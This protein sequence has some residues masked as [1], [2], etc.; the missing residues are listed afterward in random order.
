[1]L[2]NQKDF[3]SQNFLEISHIV[4]KKFQLKRFSIYFPNLS[5]PKE[6]FEMK[7]W[8]IYQIRFRIC[9]L[10]FMKIEIMFNTKV[11]I[12]SLIGNNKSRDTVKQ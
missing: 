1:V 2:S 3:F 11:F 6:F 5:F 10:F 4:M 12:F 8:I 7:L 9:N